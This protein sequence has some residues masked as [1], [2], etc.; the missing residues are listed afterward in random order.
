MPGNF[1]E[2]VET[3][4]RSPR[5]CFSSEPTNWT[6]SSPRSDEIGSNARG[7]VTFLLFVAAR[8]I[9]D[10]R[11]KFLKKLDELSDSSIRRALSSISFVYWNYA[12]VRFIIRAHAG[13]CFSSIFD[14]FVWTSADVLFEKFRDN[15]KCISFLVDSSRCRDARRDVF[16]HGFNNYNLRVEM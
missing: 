1:R 14:I 15:V 2:R 4:V 12:L 7:L 9:C 10:F 16:I 6:L 3:H 13:K 5:L 8:L 11:A